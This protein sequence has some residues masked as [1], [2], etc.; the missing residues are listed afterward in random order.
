MPVTQFTSADLLPALEQF[1]PPETFL[2]RTFFPG[3]SYFVGRFCQVELKEIERWLAPVVKRG[4]IGRVVSRE[5]YKTSFYE[6]P[7]IRA[8]RETAVTDLDDRLAGETAYSAQ[9]GSR[10]ARRDSSARSHRAGRAQPREE[11]SR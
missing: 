9:D 8:T 5:P 11:S 6:V 1:A 10:E 2:N 7:E 4:Q 3:E